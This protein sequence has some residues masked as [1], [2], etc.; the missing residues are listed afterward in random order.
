MILKRYDEF[1]I[2]DVI[3]I[4]SEEVAT[5]GRSNGWV[6]AREDMEFFA[7]KLKPLGIVYVDDMRGEWR[8]TQQN[9]NTHE[10]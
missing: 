8:M 1:P 4:I 5:R 7:L 3:S 2:R 6:G 10:D 9:K